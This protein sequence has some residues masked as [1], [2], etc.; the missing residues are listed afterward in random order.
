MVRERKEGRDRVR[1]R[2]KR[3]V[4]EGKKKLTLCASNGENYEG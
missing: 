2:E 1:V 4:R 3:R